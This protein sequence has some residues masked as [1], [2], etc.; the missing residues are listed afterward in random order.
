M[1]INVNIDQKITLEY[2][3]HVANKDRKLVF[4]DDCALEMERVQLKV[5]KIIG[6]VDKLNEKEMDAKSVDDQL[7][8]INDKYGQIRDSIIT[9]FDKYF[10]DG[11]GLEI[12]KHNHEST[13]ALATVFGS[14]YDYLDKV[15]VTG[16]RKQRRDKK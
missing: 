7:D 14:I 16:N 11:A 15:E 10:G 12:Y 9:F 8:Y 1:A 4:T 3:F 6:E 2:V 5:D 13:R